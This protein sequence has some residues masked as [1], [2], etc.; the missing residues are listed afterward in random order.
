M[1]LICVK[2]CLL[3]EHIGILTLLYCTQGLNYYLKQSFML[4]SEMLA[5]SSLDH[6]LARLQQD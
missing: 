3:K 1:L 5:F 6:G 2:V 4:S